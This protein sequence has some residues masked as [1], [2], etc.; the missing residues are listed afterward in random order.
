MDRQ[1]VDYDDSPRMVIARQEA[2]QE[3]RR[4]IAETEQALEAVKSSVD[5]G[6]IE[7]DVSAAEEL[8]NASG[9]VL[10]AM[11]SLDDLPDGTL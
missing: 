2:V 8:A 11:L 3:L 1:M 9:S 7:A 4:A 10:E 6:P 5:E